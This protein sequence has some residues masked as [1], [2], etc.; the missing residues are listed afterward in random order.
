MELAEDRVRKRE[1]AIMFEGLR[2]WVGG[3]NGKGVG[4]SEDDGRLLN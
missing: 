2:A 1:V 3:Q 4:G